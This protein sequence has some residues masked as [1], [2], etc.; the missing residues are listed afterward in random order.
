MIR[1]N[2]KNREYIGFLISYIAYLLV[3]LFFIFYSFFNLNNINWGIIGT[4]I[5]I[6][7]GIINPVLY[8][9]SLKTDEEE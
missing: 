6:I 1:L 3:L 2:M 5:L 7:T 8:Y 9:R 4:I